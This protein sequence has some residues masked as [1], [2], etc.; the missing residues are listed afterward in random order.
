MKKFKKI[1][2]DAVIFKSFETDA[3]D[4]T[5][6][7][8][9]DDNIQQICH[10][11][12]SDNPN[13]T[14]SEL[15]TIL[16]QKLIQ[17]TKVFD[18]IEHNTRDQSNSS[19]WFDMRKGHLTVSRHYDIYKKVNT[20]VSSQGAV[21]SKTTPLIETILFPEK[22]SVTNAAIRWGIDNELDSLKFFYAEYFNK[23]TLTKTRSSKL[24]KVD[25][26]FLKTI[27]I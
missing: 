20:V 9:M 5:E 11:I 16:F 14:E 13:A 22:F 7:S 19:L 18:L 6:I 24:K 4:Q 27:H 3:A 1:N 23:Q 2:Q 15:T 8:F 17:M 10:N 26:I 25:C 12:L 21:K